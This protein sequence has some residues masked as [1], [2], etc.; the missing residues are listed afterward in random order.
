MNNITSN[1]IIKATKK[2]L[3]LY[4]IL[5]TLVLFG[6]SCFVLSPLYVSLSSNIVYRDSLLS[7]FLNLVNNVFYIAV[8]T[9]CFSA[10]IYSVYKCGTR[11]SVSLTVVYCVAILLRYMANII[12]QTFTDGVFPSFADLFPAIL[13]CIFDIL[14]A[15]AVLWIAHLCLGKDKVKGSCLPFEKLY[16]HSNPLQKASLFTGILLS[17][18]KVLTRI[19]YDFGYGAPTSILDL[20]RMIV[21]YLSDLLICVIIYLFSLLLFMHFYKKDN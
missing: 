13:G 7:D 10:F 1:E 8:Y 18:I 4:V 19:I 17:S 12:I 16:Q 6:L 14:T 2:R 15:F 5:T 9:V 20:L 11:R 3:R 21:Y